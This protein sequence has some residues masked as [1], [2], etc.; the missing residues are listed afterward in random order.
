M[1]DTKDAYLRLLKQFEQGYLPFEDFQKMKE[2]IFSIQP[3]E[4]GIH[5]HKRMS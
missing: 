2:V 4:Y 3:P 5:F 1:I